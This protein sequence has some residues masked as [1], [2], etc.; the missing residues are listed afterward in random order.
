MKK[1]VFI[2]EKTNDGFSA[3][4][5]DKS[6]AVG[7]SGSSM[8]ELKG[9]IVDAYNSYADEMGVEEA[10]I[11]EIQIQLDVPQFFEFYKV[12]NAS[13]L[14]GLIGMD[15]TLISQYVNG[16]KKPGPKQ[17]YKILS[18]IRQLGKEL[19]ELDLSVS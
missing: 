13:A 8:T 18:G 9:N 7:T 19:F 11:D 1:I 15:K 6:I 17:V 3:Y 2:V 5:L 10:S 4:A 12:I 16:H 14:G